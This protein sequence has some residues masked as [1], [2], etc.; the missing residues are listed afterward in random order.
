MVTL[1]L[2]FLLLVCHLGPFLSNSIALL[3]VNSSTDWVTL[4]LDGLPS[5][6]ISNSNPTTSSAVLLLVTV[7]GV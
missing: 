7:T 1:P 2:T 5:V 4:I 6:S 3:S